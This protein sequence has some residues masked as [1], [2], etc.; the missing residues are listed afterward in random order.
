M[1]KRCLY[2]HVHFS[3]IHIRQKVETM[4]VSIY[5]QVNIENTVRI[6]TNSPIK[7]I[8]LWQNR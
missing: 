5:E 8:H 2:S 3:N 7:K 6:Y 1:C 4:Q